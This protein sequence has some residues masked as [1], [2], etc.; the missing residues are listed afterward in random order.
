MSFLLDPLLLIIIG[1]IGGKINY[2]IM[3]FSHRFFERRSYRIVNY[4]IHKNLFIIGLV[5]IAIFW[6]YSSFLYLNLIYFP[7]PFPKVWT[8]SDWMLNSGLPLGVTKTYATNI[9]AIIIFASYPFWFWLGTEFAVGTGLRITWGKKRDD[10]RDE[11]IKALVITVF[12]KDGA[13]PIGAGAVDEKRVVDFFN[14]LPPLSKREAALL[15]YV[16]DSR[17]FV[18]TLIGKWSRFVNLDE[19]GRTGTTE[20]RR[21]FDAWESNRF[22]LNAAAFFKLICLFGYYTK[23]DVWKYIGYK[24]PSR[25]EDP[26]WYRCTILLLWWWYFVNP[27]Q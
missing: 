19:K 26:P 23:E 12:P 20:K 25:P 17:L 21:Y 24:G 1:L 22:L 8:G 27:G 14:K 10:E 15:L 16:F 3:P 2:L 5:V 13:I 6:I 4:R 18:L 9:V 7:W 11:I